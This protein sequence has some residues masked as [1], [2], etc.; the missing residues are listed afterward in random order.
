MTAVQ[1][2][3]LTTL[4]NGLR[5]IT[6]TMPGIR[7]VG[8]GCWIDTGTRDE[9]PHEAGASHFLEHLL[10]KG[11]DRL[12]AREISRRFDAMGAES[13]AF[14]SK[15]HTCF[16]ARLLDDDLPEGLGILAQMLQEP[17]FRPA[18]VDSER[19][20]VFE[21][22]S[23]SEDDPADLA[24]ERFT[25]SLFAGHPLAEPV[26]GT[27]AS[28]EGMSPEALRGYWLRRYGVRSTVVAMAGSVSHQ[29]AVEMVDGLF[30]D[31][32][33]EPVE[34]AHAALAIEPAV[35][36]LHRPHEQA[37]L[38]LG[39]EGMHRADD[40][41]WAFEV[42]NLILG[43][44]MA[45]RLFTSVREERGLAYTVHSFRSW[46]ADAG[47]W[48]VYLATRPA[49]VGE[50]LDVVEAELAALAEDGIT[51]EELERAKGSIRGGFALAMEDSNTRMVRLGRDELIG[52]EHWSI[53]ERIARI[54][55]VTLEDVGAV[56]REFLRGPRV[57][58]AVGPLEQPDLD[59]YVA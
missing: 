30:G 46:Y 4:P 53:D 56:A 27:R 22:I 2:Y 5:V 20:V 52:A 45:S 49:K 33:G 48:G 8:L 41:R 28:I 11:T 34:H 26:L 9:Q 31:W 43:G 38:V 47:A 58:S 16:W 15:D 1:H 18:D 55:A 13:N 50:A 23:E 51:E 44:G 54:E 6:E 21:E 14:T 37:H 25:G 3:Q 35:S 10:F 24:F 12:S 29:A 36:V 32:T 40:R 17:A 57:L 39:G 59:R 7:S 42:M 19:E